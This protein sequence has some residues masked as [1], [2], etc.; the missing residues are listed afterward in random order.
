MPDTTIT[1]PAA[2]DP[3]DRLILGATDARG[4]V[5]LTIGVALYGCMAEE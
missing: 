4:P 2:I 1:A 5:P 3:V